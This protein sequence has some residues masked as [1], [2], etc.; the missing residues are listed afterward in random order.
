MNAREKAWT[1]YR[2][3]V[4]EKS[5]EMICGE[6]FLEMAANVFVV[7]SCSA[8]MWFIRQRQMVLVFLILRSYDEDDD[9]EEESEKSSSSSKTSGS[10]G[11]GAC[12]TPPS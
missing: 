7:N 2:D 1:Y 10:S 12:S 8:K 5:G 6:I 11:L 4:L 3:V 9:N